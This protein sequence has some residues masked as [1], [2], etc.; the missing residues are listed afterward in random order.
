MKIEYFDI[1][2]IDKVAAMAAE[3][4]GYKERSAEYNR[5]FCGHLSRYSCYTPE[6]ALQAS[7]DEGLQAIAF[8]WLPGDTNDADA[9]VERNL[10]ALPPDEREG[11]MRNVDY[12]KHTDAELQ[13]AMEPGVS[14]KLAFFISRK[15]GFGTPLLERLTGLLHDRG[16]KW[17][18]L[19]TD[20]SCSWQYYPRHGY[21]QIGFGRVPEYSTPDEDY[22]YMFFRK[23][24][25]R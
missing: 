2:D 12:L 20:S 8:G 6:L 25:K 13:R 3:V 17:L 11:V 1:K 15:P 21:E 14:A 7:D 10:G 18:Y 19:W 22:N 24:I 4:W 23:N 5:V 9:W 16:A